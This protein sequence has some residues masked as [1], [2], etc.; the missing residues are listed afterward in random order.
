M[1]SMSLM[2][3]EI[4]TACWTGRARAHAACTSSARTSKGS[5]QTS[6]VPWVWE[7]IKPASTWAQNAIHDRLIGPIRVCAIPGR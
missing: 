1:A 6:K 5:P 7:D 3:V 4:R 2:D